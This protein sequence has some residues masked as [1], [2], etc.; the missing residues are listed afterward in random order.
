MGK[1]RARP[2]RN[3]SPPSSLSL[4]SLAKAQGVLPVADL[5]ELSVL[6]PEQ[7]DPDQLLAFIERERKARRSLL[8][9]DGQH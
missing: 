5:D 1:T 9:N 8:V 7:N 2:N 6:W 3:P 4:E